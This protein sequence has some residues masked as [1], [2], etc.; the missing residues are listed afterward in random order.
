MSDAGDPHF[1]G[2]VTQKAIL[3]ADPG[4]ILLVRSSPDR[5]WSIPGGR[6][7]DDEPTDAAIA[8]ELHEETGLNAAIGPPVQTLTNAWYTD[9]GNPMYTVIYAAETTDKTVTLNH[10]HDD[11]TWA[12]IDDAKTQ[13]PLDGLVDAIDRAT[14]WWTES[15]R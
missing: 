1:R 7:H 8:R 10:E 2:Q 4:E 6:I 13:V 5:P 12:P 9:D 15:P 11:Y 3:F 14:N